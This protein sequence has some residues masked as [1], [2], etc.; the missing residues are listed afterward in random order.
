MQFNEWYDCTAEQYNQT[1]EDKAN[2]KAEKEDAKKNAK[3]EA[4]RLQTEEEERHIAQAEAA[5]QQKIAEEEARRL[6]E[7]EEEKLRQ[8]AGKFLSKAFYICFAKRD[9]Y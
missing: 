5:A 9:L 6:A 7:E 3:A 1:L 4:A 8:A 2:A